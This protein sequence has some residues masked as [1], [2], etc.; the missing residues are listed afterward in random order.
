M[1]HV[2]EEVNLG[3]WSVV[4]Y[5]KGNDIIFKAKHKSG[6]ERYIKYRYDRY[7]E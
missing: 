5:L 1:R 4:G 3:S 7:I 6:R 2:F